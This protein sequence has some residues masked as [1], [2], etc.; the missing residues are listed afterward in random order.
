MKVLRGG[1]VRV[2]DELVDVCKTKTNLVAA[3]NL[4]AANSTSVGKAVAP[5]GGD[6]SL[7]QTFGRDSLENEYYVCLDAPQRG[8][9]SDTVNNCA[10]PGMA[11]EISTEATNLRTISEDGKV[12]DSALQSFPCVSVLETVKNNYE[13]NERWTVSR[14]A[15]SQG[16]CT[17]AISSAPPN[18]MSAS[19]DC[20]DI[21]DRMENR[22]VSTESSTKVPNRTDFLQSE[23]QPPNKNQNGAAKSG[24]KSRW[25]PKAGEIFDAESSKCGDLPAGATFTV[26]EQVSRDACRLQSGKPEISEQSRCDEIGCWKVEGIPQ[27]VRQVPSEDKILSAPKIADDQE[28]LARVSL[29]PDTINKTVAETQCEEPLNEDR[30]V[31]VRIILLIS[32]YNLI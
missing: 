19:F 22:S 28:L 8:R 29:E 18:S 2:S 1:N 14:T 17:L 5:N 13:T 24:R 21:K 15:T 25:G 26:S 9:L 6:V 10:T 12:P 32:H 27:G 4:K 23:K 30:T 20:N 11:D 7:G 3:D 16:K 31:E